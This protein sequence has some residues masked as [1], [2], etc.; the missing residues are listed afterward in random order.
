MTAVEMLVLENLWGLVMYRHNVLKTGMYKKKICQ[1]CTENR[2]KHPHNRLSSSF[3]DVLS[4]LRM[5]RTLHDYTGT[6]LHEN[7]NTSRIREASLK[8]EN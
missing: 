4:F 8:A 5:S 2:L 3:K 7:W 1:Y 6:L